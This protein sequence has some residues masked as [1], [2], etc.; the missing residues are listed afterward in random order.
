[1]PQPYKANS[2]QATHN[3]MAT[4]YYIGLMSGT[5]ADGIDAALVQFDDHESPSAHLIS[6]L[7]T[8]FDPAIRDKLFTLFA[9]Q[10]SSK[11]Q[12]D[13]LGELDTELGLCF[14]Q[15]CLDL[16][17]NAG[18]SKS[19]IRAIGSHGQTIRHRPSGDFPFTLQIGNAHAIAERTGIDVVADFRRRDLMLG[20]QGAPLAPA[21]HRE[22]LAC[23]NESR[24]VLNIGG[25][26]NITWLSK[27]GTGLLGFDTGPG[28]GL[29]DE[30]IAKHKQLEYDKAGAWASSGSVDATLV[31]TLLADPYFSLAPPK[32]TGKEYFHLRWAKERYE[33]LENVAPE[34]IQASFLELS[35]A[36]I[37]NAI[38]QHCAGVERVLVCGGGAHNSA[39]MQRLNALCPSP[40]ESC[41]VVGI[42]PDWVEAMAFAWLAKCYME[43]RALSLAPITGSSKPVLPGALFKAAIN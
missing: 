24:V 5:S 43:G 41:T 25:I 18:V 19:K 17:H 23:S 22:F 7:F 14:A 10:T 39:L 33:S 34:D 30:W 26:A 29:M 2:W 16:I 20:G 40:V 8:P 15:A 38:A 12:L 9:P 32:S 28:N 36:S 4:D 37:S 42:N 27:K 21:F 31:S 13:L 35:A 1:M 6:S 3:L 11:D